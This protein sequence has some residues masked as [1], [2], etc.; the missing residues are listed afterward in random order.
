MH[1]S[2]FIALAIAMYFADVMDQT[3]E[4]P[5][6]IHLGRAAQTEAPQPVRRGD[7]GEDRLDYTEPT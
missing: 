3:E 1:T 6:R 7:V 4:L 2:V 5:S